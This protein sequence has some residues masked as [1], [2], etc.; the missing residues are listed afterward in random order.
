MTRDDGG[1]LLVGRIGD[2]L[3]LAVGKPVD[4]RNGDA[5]KRVVDAG[6]V[7]AFEDQIGLNENWQEGSRRSLAVL[8]VRLAIL[9]DDPRRRLALLERPRECARHVVRVDIDQ[10]VRTI[11][12]GPRPAS[13][14]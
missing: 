9:M 8:D 1:R 4:A 6:L 5:Q 13:P 11:A 12:F 3:R 10:H 7:H 14:R 2:L